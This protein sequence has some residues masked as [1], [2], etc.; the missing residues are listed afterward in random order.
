MK[1]LE[2]LNRLNGLNTLNS[3]ANLLNEK[4]EEQTNKKK[5]FNSKL[6]ANKEYNSKKFKDVDW[7]NVK[8]S[9]NNNNKEPLDLTDKFALTLGYDRTDSVSDLN[10][11]KRKL[12]DGI[13]KPGKT[14]DTGSIQPFINNNLF[15]SSGMEQRG[16]GLERLVEYVDTYHNEKNWTGTRQYV[17]DNERHVKYL[18]RDNQQSDAMKDLFLA[19]KRLFEDDKVWQ[20]KVEAKM[21]DGDIE[22]YYSMWEG[23]PRQNSIEILLGNA[24][25]WEALKSGNATVEPLSGVNCLIDLL[26]NSTVDGDKL[27]FDD[28]FEYTTEE[29]GFSNVGTNP[30]V[31]AY[32]IKIGQNS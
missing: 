7:N 21:V 22:G 5:E 13:F 9:N 11:L 17:M 26:V 3:K 1:R 30:P 29:A 14:E 18:Y 15:A 23:H 6:F 2:R 25:E 4:V 32:V 12:F 16:V 28:A 20:P 10:Y 19:P 24:K 27:K 8:G 31:D